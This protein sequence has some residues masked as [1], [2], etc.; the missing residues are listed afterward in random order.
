M[1][2]VLFKIGSIEI[3]SYGVM[4]ALGILLAWWYFKRQFPS[5]INQ[6]RLSN[7]VIAS[8]I[9]GLVGARINF[10]IEHAGEI[11]DLRDFFSML[12]SRSGLTAYGGFLA[13]ITA[14]YLYARK[15]GLPVLK[16]LDAGTFAMCIGYFFG[17]LGC[18]LAG[19]GDYGT[20]SNLPWAMA[21]PNGTVPTYERVH[22]VPVYE[23]ILIALIFFILK[24]VQKHHAPDGSVFALFLMLFG[25]ERFFM[26]FIRF[27]PK[28]LWGITEVQFVSLGLMLTGAWMW[29]R[30]RKATPTIATV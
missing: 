2:P 3:G 10:M 7:L 22:P 12:F 18:Q 1:Y 17:R 27:N 16:V 13:G 19:D 4:L 9:A 14:G 11:Q 21:Y 8:I 6:E 30:I 25:L 5:E 20:P 28:I 15:Q 24:R 29:I 26:E 23:M